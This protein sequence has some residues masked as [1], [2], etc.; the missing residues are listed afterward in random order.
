[1]D[2]YQEAVSA[3]TRDSS[4]NRRTNLIDP[5]QLLPIQVFG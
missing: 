1:M 4:D 2:N 5:I 3:T